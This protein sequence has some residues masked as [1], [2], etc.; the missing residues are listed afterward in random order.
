MGRSVEVCRRAR[1]LVSGHDVWMINDTR[2]NARGTIAAAA[3]VWHLT[4]RNG[5]CADEYAYK[6]C[7][8]QTIAGEGR[9]PDVQ[10]AMSAGSV[11]PLEFSKIAG[12]AEAPRTAA[13]GTVR[14]NE[15]RDT[16]EGPVGLALNRYRHVPPPKDG[17]PTSAHWRDGRVS[18][19]CVGDSPPPPPY[20]TRQPDAAVAGAALEYPTLKKDCRSKR[21]VGDKAAPSPYGTRQPDTAAAGG[22]SIAAA[23]KPARY[24]GDSSP[25]YSVAAQASDHHNSFCNR[26]RNPSSLRRWPRSN[27][28]CPAPSS[29]NDVEGVFSPVATL[30]SYTLTSP[31][32]NYPVPSFLP[33][34]GDCFAAI[35]SP[36]SAA[37]D[38][39][40]RHQLGW[41]FSEHGPTLPVGSAAAFNAAQHHQ[42]GLASTVRQTSGGAR[43][44]DF[45][46]E[47]WLH[48][49]NEQDATGVVCSGLRRLSSRSNIISWVLYTP[50]KHLGG[51]QNPRF[52]N[53]PQ[54]HGF[55]SQG[56]R[57]YHQ[58]ISIWGVFQNSSFANQPQPDGFA[59][60]GLQ[61]PLVSFLMNLVRL[62]VYYE[63]REEDRHT[64]HTISWVFRIP[65]LCLTWPVSRL[66]HTSAE[67]TGQTGRYNADL[68][69]QRAVP[70]DEL[71]ARDVRS[72]GRLAGPESSRSLSVAT[73]GIRHL[74][75]YTV[76]AYNSGYYTVRADNSDLTRLGQAR[77]L[78]H[79]TV[80]AGTF[81]MTRSEQT[82][83]T[84]SG[85]R[86]SRLAGTPASKRPPRASGIASE[87]P[88]PEPDVCPAPT[89]GE[90]LGLCLDIGLAGMVSGSESLVTGRWSLAARSPVSS[91]LEKELWTLPGGTILDSPG[92]GLASA[93]PTTSKV[94]WSRKLMDK[95]HKTFISNDT[96]FRLTCWRARIAHGQKR[97]TFDPLEDPRS[98]R[99][100]R[101]SEFMARGGVRRHRPDLAAA[102]RLS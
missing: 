31:S 4:V 14:H 36:S 81:D 47:P 53:E 98:R 34:H 65:S 77:H 75:L 25:N 18:K 15:T 30:S 63:D 42:L 55:T 21:C 91:P 44:P 29:E 72:G 35:P 17:L 28:R 73:E 22:I 50:S 33:C 84:P 7:R 97:R 93:F 12:A 66:R 49:G 43:I 11:F 27:W 24:S 40:Q 78:R 10:P 60:Q 45:V 92:R 70:S 69:S 74:R 90:R 1:A 79:D 5:G 100:Q 99:H 57:Y 85:D 56:S 37:L 67:S 59:T 2:L 62:L 13:A 61:Q 48:A 80:G 68:T 83:P 46:N 19:R 82:P 41:R 94:L 52:A 51:F 88:I 86:W 87:E 96:I 9:P 3:G 26:F 102:A 95:Y 58:Q 20:G 89:F 101:V 16:P 64:A 54:S 38:T 6:M 39:A 8:R 23:R 32:Y 76:G 71:A